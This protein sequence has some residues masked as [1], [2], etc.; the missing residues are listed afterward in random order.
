MKNKAKPKNAVREFKNNVI[1]LALLHSK[2]RFASESHKV[3]NT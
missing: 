3:K 1:V 2:P